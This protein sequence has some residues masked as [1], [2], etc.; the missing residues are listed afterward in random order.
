[1]CAVSRFGRV[2]L[3]NNNTGFW[4]DY[5]IKHVPSI[6]ALLPRLGARGILTTMIDPAN[7]ARRSLAL[8]EGYLT[9]LLATA[10]ESG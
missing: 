1:M 3:G 6:G 2:S 5:L 7:L 10:P 4:R 8:W 9:A